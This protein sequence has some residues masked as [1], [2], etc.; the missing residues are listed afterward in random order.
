MLL[1]WPAWGSTTKVECADASAMAWLVG[2]GINASFSLVMMSVGMSVPRKTAVRSGRSAMPREAAAI[3]SGRWRAIMASTVFANSGKV[4]RVCSESSLG[5]MARAITALPLV[6]A[7]K[8][9]ASRPCLASSVSAGAARVAQDEAR[10]ALRPALQKGKGHI[11]A[12]GKATEHGA[13]DALRIEL[14]FQLLGQLF[15]G[16]HRWHFLSRFEGKEVRGQHVGNTFQGFQIRLPHGMVQWEAV[17]EEEVWAS[18]H[19]ARLR[20][21]CWRVGCRSL[22]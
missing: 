12:H 3:A 20:R 19:G 16:Q 17:D 9:V 18:V 22:P 21:S 15:H 1:R 10:Y 6:S 4:E 11:A 8:A 5:V 14:R 7:S 2:S 13:L